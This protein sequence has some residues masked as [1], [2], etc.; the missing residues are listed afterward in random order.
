[1]TDVKYS[2]GEEK[3]L[4]APKVEG[5]EILL[6]TVHRG[7]HAQVHHVMLSGTV[8]DE[9]QAEALAELLTKLMSVKHRVAVRDVFG[10]SESPKEKTND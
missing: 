9:I 6:V 2:G 1:M 4:L 8:I 5:D 10:A 3:Y 7:I